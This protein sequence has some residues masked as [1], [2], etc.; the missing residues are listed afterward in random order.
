[1]K[2]IQSITIFSLAIG[3]ALSSFN[4]KTLNANAEDMNVREVEALLDERMDGMSQAQ[5]H[6]LTLQLFKLCHKYNF[7]VSSVLSVISTESSF[8]KNAKSSVG[9]IGLMQVMPKTA[10]FIARK[11]GIRS[12]HRARD[13]YNP[14]TN[15]AVGI[16]YLSYLRDKYT[17]SH[18]Y[19]AAYNMGPTKFNRMV[20]RHSPHPASV[21]RYVKSI[22]SGVYEIRREAQELAYAQT[23]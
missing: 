15:V 8:D 19:L 23:E 3:M 22:H 14:S 11:S 4:A 17:Q 2:Y 6:S 16:A 21:N 5:V 18:R 1:M 7:S 12:Y 13:L 20:R 10:G 9:A